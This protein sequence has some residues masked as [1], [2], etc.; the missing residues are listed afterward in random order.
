MTEEYA[1]VYAG[2]STVDGSAMLL[3]TSG[4]VT[5]HPYFFDGFVEH[6]QVAVWIAHGTSTRIAI[7]CTIGCLVTTRANPRSVQCR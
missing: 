4:G 7:L 1:Y 5:A 3:A 6:A 2:E